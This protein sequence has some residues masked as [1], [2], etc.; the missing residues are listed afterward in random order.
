MGASA[1]ESISSAIVQLVYSAIILLYIFVILGMTPW[2]F[3]KVAQ[4]ILN[5][6]LHK[7]K[8][9]IHIGSLHVSIIHMKFHVQNLYLVMPTMSIQ[10]S[11]LFI[12]YKT[13]KNAQIQTTKQLTD[14]IMQNIATQTKLEIKSCPLNIEISGMQIH[15]F[16][17][18]EIT[19]AQIEQKLQLAKYPFIFKI[20]PAIYLKISAFRIVVGNNQMRLLASIDI[21]LYET[22]LGYQKA[23]KDTDVHQL[24]IDGCINRS[25]ISKKQF[26]VQLLENDS[27]QCN[28]DKMFMTKK[29][30]Q[31]LVIPIIQSDYVRI[32]MNKGAGGYHTETCTDQ[33]YTDNE[34]PMNQINI[35]MKQ[36]SV[37]FSAWTLREILN[38]MDIF[39]PNDFTPRN[40][41]KVQTNTVRVSRSL[42]IGI[43]F[44]D[45]V[46]I[47]YWNLNTDLP[48]KPELCDPIVWWKRKNSGDGFYKH[49]NFLHQEE[50]KE[51]KQV[52]NESLD[53]D[54]KIMYNQRKILKEQKLC[55]LYYL[56]TMDYDELIQK[57]HEP[58]VPLF[59]GYLKPIETMQIK[60]KQ[61]S[62]V[63]LRLG[64]S[65]VEYYSNT[66]EKIEQFGNKG[67][68][69][70]IIKSPSVSLTSQIFDQ[71][72]IVSDDFEFLLHRYQFGRM[73]KSESTMEIGINTVMGGGIAFSCLLCEQLYIKI[74]CHFQ[75]G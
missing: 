2:F 7:K 29:S 57:V 53:N 65:I 67:S 75:C 4:L 60:L 63:Q 33:E 13:I 34:A 9:N 69:S 44:D 37:A 15:I 56:H 41:I 51:Q 54:L 40:I 5:A 3:G 16:S 28:N 23:V 70:L 66:S 58:K 11:D 30:Q 47:I 49:S 64:G 6:V 19:G 38:I 45:D 48:Y 55:K 52:D 1:L 18:T 73:I 61:N 12:H 59:N 50:E 21:P 62:Q 32:S 39:I 72:F 24:V 43:Y 25:P 27:Y 17:R 68:M 36:T 10:M 74:F 22:V 31:T 46:P 71:E 8:M 35:R 14:Y 42:Y 20:I 26:Q